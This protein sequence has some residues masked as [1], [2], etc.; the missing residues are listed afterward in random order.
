MRAGQRINLFLMCFDR[1]GVVKRKVKYFFT[2][3]RNFTILTFIVDQE[4]MCNDI[5][6]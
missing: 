5:D 2:I 1:K 4:D 3:D 6:L